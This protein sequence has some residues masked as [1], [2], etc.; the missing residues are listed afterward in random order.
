MD[1]HLGY[2]QGYQD[3]Q[4]G[5]GSDPVYASP[6]FRKGYLDG[7]RNGVIDAQKGTYNPQTLEL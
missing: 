5:I 2:V 6:E 1:Y 7:H 4:K 3:A